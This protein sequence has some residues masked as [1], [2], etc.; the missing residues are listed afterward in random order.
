MSSKLKYFS[1]QEYDI[2]IQ[3]QD[4]FL[5]MDEETVARIWLTVNLTVKFGNYQEN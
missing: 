2:L 3:G 1:T 4:E 5:R